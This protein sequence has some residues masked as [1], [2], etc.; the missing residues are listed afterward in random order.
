ME[1]FEEYYWGVFYP[2]G[3]FYRGALGASEEEAIGIFNY[4]HGL[5]QKTLAENHTSRKVKVGLY[6][7]GK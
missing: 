2:N 5:N 1:K 6:E 3:D 4:L 7:E